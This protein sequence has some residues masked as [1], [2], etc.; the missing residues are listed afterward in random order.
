MTS[1]RQLRY[2]EALAR[3]RHFG[4]AAEACG[5]TQPALS[6]QIRELEAHLRVALVERGREGVRLTAA[7][8]DVLARTRSILIA[9]SDLETAAAAQG[10]VLD[11]RFR[12]G[13]IPSIAPFLLPRLL[14][15]VR[16]RFPT[17]DLALRET[18]TD[19]LLGE[20]LA[21]ELDAAILSLPVDSADCLSLP[22]FD[23]AFLLAVPAGAEAFAGENA[24]RAEHLDRAD[25]LLLEDGHCLRAQ[26]LQVCAHVDPRR[27][28]SYGATSLTTIMQL[29][30]NGQGVTLLPELF[31][32]AEGA[33]DG[34]VRLL[35]FAEP[36]PRRHVG[37]V[38]RRS[39]PHRADMDA[40]AGLVRE[41]RG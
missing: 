35:R 21:G 37:L 36:Q 12:L 16:Q 17:L 18:Q 26:A 11:G 8:E 13:I 41:C 6:M 28:R 3:T 33:G 29:V 38:W 1:F 4:R 25:L 5:V 14:P 10:G 34:R 19:V 22:L 15:L 39:A 9:V 24:A 31:V 2:F 27:L 40:F 20:L 30:A 32:E 7:G 23:D